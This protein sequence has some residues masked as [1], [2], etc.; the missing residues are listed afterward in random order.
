M[1]LTDQEIGKLLSD[2]GYIKTMVE[3]LDKTLTDDCATKAI[4]DQLR[5]D[6][7]SKIT[8]EEFNPVKQL[9]YGLVGL[10]LTSFVLGIIGLLVTKVKVI[11]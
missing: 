2:V 1:A 8:R 6:I 9:V 11:P 4:T 10:V 3:R 7:N 5:T